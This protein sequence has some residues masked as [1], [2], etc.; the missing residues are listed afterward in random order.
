[1]VTVHGIGFQQPPA[2]GSLGYADSLHQ[3]LVAALPDLVSD[4]ADR[5]PYQQGRLSRSMSA[6]DGRCWTALPR[7]GSAAHGLR[8]A[9]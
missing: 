3:N 7:M 1:M 2:D 8:T 6:A 9:P 5:R 4:D